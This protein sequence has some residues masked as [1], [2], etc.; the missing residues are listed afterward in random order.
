MVKGSKHV[1][2]AKVLLNWG[3]SR[4][5]HEI[6]NKY[7]GIAGMPG[8]NSGPPNSI[9]DGLKYAA[10]YSL[11]WSIDNRQRILSEWAKRYDAKSEPKNN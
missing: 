2:A 7:Y 6:F 4:E 11:D 1:E 8:L 3:A 10:D 9:P 5:A